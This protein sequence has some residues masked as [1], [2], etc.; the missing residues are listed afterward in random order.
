MHPVRTGWFRR[1]ALA[2]ILALL[3]LASLW[4]GWTASSL[5]REARIRTWTLEAAEIGAF[6][7]AALARGNDLL[8]VERFSRLSRRDDIAFMM[9]MD[10]EGKARLHTDVAQTGKAFAGVYAD[11]AAA[12]ADILVQPESAAGLLEIDFPLG[13]AGVLRAGFVSGSATPGDGWMWAGLGLALAGMLL[14]A[15]PALRAADKL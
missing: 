15:L 3:G 5:S 6:A 10:A 7:R 12:A 11:R 13:S 14:S 4:C 2:M 1:A 8:V 9:V